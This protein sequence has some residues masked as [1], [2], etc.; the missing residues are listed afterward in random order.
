MKNYA[1]LSARNALSGNYIE[2]AAAVIF[3]LTVI[4]STVLLNQI[5][6]KMNIL[7]FTLPVSVIALMFL[8]CTA[9]FL[10]SA[11]L[12]KLSEKGITKT[13]ISKKRAAKGVVLTAYVSCLKLL[14]FIA[15]ISLPAVFF[16]AVYMRLKLMSVSVISLII[17]AFG[18]IVLFAV[19]LIFYGVSVQKYSKAIYF[20][21]G[22][23]AV[24]VKNAVSMSIAQTKGKLLD[25]FIFKCSFLPW[26]L[27][28]ILLLPLMFVLPYYEES[29]IFYCMY[30]RK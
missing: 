29:F 3:M 7:I 1:K 28:G 8:I 13:R 11:R 12:L 10:L 15:F 14:H 20:F 9:K 26:L 18:A 16:A 23:E 22:S 6:A 19:S 2:P 24:T 25:I 30:S 21:A 17:N 4:L 5:F 27:S